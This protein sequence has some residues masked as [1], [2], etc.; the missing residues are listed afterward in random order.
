MY[1]HLLSNK[2]IPDG[3]RNQ[4]YHVCPAILRPRNLNGAAIAGG[5]AVQQEDDPPVPL[6]PVTL[7]VDIGR[8]NI[9]CE[10]CGAKRYPKE[11]KGILFNTND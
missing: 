5:G 4:Y 1:A 6:P 7:P 8:M 2:Q 11:A 3:L 10:S 9:I